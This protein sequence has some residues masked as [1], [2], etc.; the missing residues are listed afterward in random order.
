VVSA[1]LSPVAATADW[2]ASTPEAEGLDSRRLL[3]VLN[4]IQRGEFGG[5][6]SLLVVRNERLVMEEYFNGW[7]AARPHTQQSVSK[8]VTSLAAGLA[9]DR[10]LLRVGDAVLPLFPD[11]QPIEAM[12]ANKQALT[13][14]DLLMMRT[15]LD[16]SEHIYAGSPLDQLNS[17]SCDWVRFMLDW[18]MREPPGSRWEYVSGGTILLGAVIGRAAGTR[19]DLLLGSELF[20]PMD[21]GNVGWFRGRPDGLP[22]TGGGLSLRP[23]DMAKLGTLVATGGRWRGRQLVSEAWLRES[24]RTLPETYNNFGGQPATY[25]YL[26]WGLPGGVITA[27]GARGQWILVVPEREL[28]VASTAENENEHWDAA[29]RILYDH[30]LPA[31][32]P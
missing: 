27:A 31:T 20:T 8:S 23:R 14:R 10:G 19:V 28:V 3:D 29:V 21:F 13:V 26:W 22:H 24:T 17:C 12:D 30:V 9:V 7:T 25:G 1:A 15:G 16:W 11:Y 5:I 2:P 4:R 32:P 6:N 18:P